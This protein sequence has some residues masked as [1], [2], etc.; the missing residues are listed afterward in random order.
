VS[1][2]ADFTTSEWAELKQ[3]AELVGFGMLG[4]SRSGPIGKVRELV[5]LSSCL[6]P[7]AAPRQFSQNELVV[8]LLE[9][10]RAEPLGPASYLFHRDLTGLIVAII[11]GRLNILTH[12]ERT[13]TL[14]AAKTSQTEAEGLK[15]WLL[16]IARTV[17]EASGDGWLGMG[18][19]VSEEE[20]TMLNEVATALRISAVATVPTPSELE[21]MLGL[22]PPEAKGVS[23]PGGA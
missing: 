13:A 2:R 19:K 23:S 20:A 8:A 1:R 9:D 5:A 22:A 11:I 21:R 16:W 7:G 3:A 14:L 10:A 12:C 6:A 4:V 18:R 17:A 15:Q